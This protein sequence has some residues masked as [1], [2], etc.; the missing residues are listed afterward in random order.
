[1][2]NNVPVIS[3]VYMPIIKL[4]QRRAWRKESNN[5][6][7]WACYRTSYDTADTEFSKPNRNLR[8]ELQV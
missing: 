4:T 1:M 7:L 8:A 2:K 5:I 6:L 3:S